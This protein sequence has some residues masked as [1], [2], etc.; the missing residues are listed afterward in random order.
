MSRGHTADEQEGAED[1]F[2]L[3][4]FFAFWSAETVS[5]FGTYITMLAVQ[6][7]VVLLLGGTAMDVGLV[8]A[9]GLLPNLL[10]PL[11][12]AIVERFRRARVL[13]A[14]DIGNGSVL[15]LLPL[16]WTIGRL[17]TPTLMVIMFSSGV[18]TVLNRAASQSILPRLVPP[19][20]LLAA[21][22]RLDQ[23]ATVAQTSGGFIAGTLIAILGAPIAVL[24][25]AASYFASAAAIATLRLE[26]PR[27]VLDHRLRSLPGEIAEGMRWIYTHPMLRPLAISTHVWFLANGIVGTVFAAFAL[28]ALHIGPFWLG[29]TYAAA[30][31]SGLAG[32]LLAVRVGRRLGAGRTVI[33]CRALTA[34]A[35]VPVAALPEEASLW[36]AIPLL[37]L[38]QA[39][40]GFSIG[41]ENASEMSF[42]QAATPDPLQARVNASRR[43]INRAMIVVG[44]PA[45]GFLVGMVGY[46]LTAWIAVALFAV[47]VGVVA[48][49]AFRR[50]T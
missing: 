19:Q 23:G 14:T 46:G 45:G 20:H 34:L 36:T 47:A 49:S 2:R 39:L 11:A 44:A 15:C 13:V 7:V 30:G 29:F 18:L 28:L 40:F 16:L 3:P 37:T 9:A 50:A 12:G 41:V 21:N 38:G 6:T 26:E 35:W 32:S 31:V 33:A 27:P 24:V 4:R 25:D 43:S 22:A 5:G 1:V 48:R 42:W 10:G 8:N 17:N